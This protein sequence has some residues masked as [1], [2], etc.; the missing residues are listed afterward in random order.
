MADLLSGVLPLG[1]VL[2]S[3]PAAAEAPQPEAG[4]EGFAELRAHASVGADGEPFFERLRPTVDARWGDRLAASVTVEAALRQGRDA[5]DE[6]Q[7]TLR[8]SE[9][10]PS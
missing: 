1:L 4:L 2:G 3:S 7:R 8:S 6:L 5:G 10:G 9:L